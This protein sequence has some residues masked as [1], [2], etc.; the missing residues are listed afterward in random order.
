MGYIRHHALIVT[1][2]F[3]GVME[4]THN[5]A[6]EIA[7]KHKKE[8][9]VSPII[10]SRMNSYETFMIIPDGSKEG[11]EDSETGN[12]IRS[13]LIS[14]MKNRAEQDDCY[15]MPGWV[16]VQYGDEEGMTKIVSHSDE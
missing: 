12:D 7:K 4:E 10:N 9:L 13:K 3:E 14:Y 8:H 1:S 6:I 11:W 15:F 16:L 5:Q 2:C